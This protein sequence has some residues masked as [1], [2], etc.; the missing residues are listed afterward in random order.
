MQTRLSLAVMVL[1]ELRKSWSRVTFEGFVLSAAKL[2]EISD[3]ITGDKSLFSSSIAC[4]KNLFINKVI[5]RLLYFFFLIYIVNFA[6]LY[7][8]KHI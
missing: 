2:S 5:W 3:G 8:F 6:K 7:H 1:A 4:R